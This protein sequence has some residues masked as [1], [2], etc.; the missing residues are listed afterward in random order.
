MAYPEHSTREITG[1]HGVHCSFFVTV[2]LPMGPLPRHC[3][4]VHAPERLH[5]RCHWSQVGEAEASKQFLSRR[6]CGLSR[7]S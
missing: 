2:P 5:N 7:N 4:E 3:A 1:V 6:G